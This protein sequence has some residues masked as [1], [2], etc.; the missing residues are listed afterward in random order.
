V[1]GWSSLHD[2]VVL[3][4]RN[5]R[6]LECVLGEWVSDLVR[7]CP[8]LE[9]LDELVVD[10]FL[11]VDPRTRTAAL[12]VVEEDTEVDPR[13]GILDIGILKDDIR[14]LATQLERDLLQVRPCGGLHDLA[15]DN[16]AT[17]ESNLVYVHVG[18]ERSTGDLAETGENIDDTRWESGLL[19]ELS[20][21][22]GTKRGLFGGLEDH[23]VTAGDGWTNFP[24]PHKE[25]EVPWDN[26]GTDTN[27]SIV[28]LLSLHLPYILGYSQVPAWCS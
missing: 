28:S 16:G 25:G 19:D 23:G 15:A 14:T 13:D 4:L 3:Q 27:L 7:L 20:G 9:F 11:H 1:G 2:A 8:L 18:G 24:C 21:I 22:E 26:L 5:L 17:G 10:T 6:A 12:A